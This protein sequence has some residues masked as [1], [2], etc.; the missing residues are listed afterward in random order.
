[1]FETCPQRKVAIAYLLKKASG[2]PLNIVVV[3][4]VSNGAVLSML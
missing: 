1:M 2:V 4:S 3:Y